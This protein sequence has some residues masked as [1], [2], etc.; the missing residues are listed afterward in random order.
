MKDTIQAVFLK[1]ARE[2]R[3]DV[4]HSI[5]SGHLSPVLRSVFRSTNR[6][7]QTFEESI[8]DLLLFLY[9]GPDY[10]QKAGLPPYSI[11]TQIRSPSSVFSW[12]ASTYRIRLL[13]TNS[14]LMPALTFPAAAETAGQESC[15]Y[16]REELCDAIAR[17]INDCNPTGRF[18]IL[19]WLLTVLEPGNAIPQ[20]PMAEAAGMTPANYRV[21]TSRSKARLARLLQRRHAGS[22]EPDTGSDEMSARLQDGFD[23]LYDCLLFY[24]D[25]AVAGL[26]NSRQVSRL[27]ALLEKEA[28]RRLHEKKYWMQL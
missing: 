24:Y 10:M 8:D 17:C 16:S 25:D 1:A 3:T 27:L 28:G 14:R 18:L 22:L 2:A 15:G 6:V 5:L 11:L 9:H 26:P 23:N 4:V 12:I 19:R 20:A 21:A 7:E 13:Q